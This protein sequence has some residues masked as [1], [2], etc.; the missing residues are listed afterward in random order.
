MK[1]LFLLLFL[2]LAFAGSST[3]LATPCV[4]ELNAATSV[5]LHAPIA[6][7]GQ[8]TETIFRGA[9]P[10][11]EEDYQYLKSIGI[12]TIISLETMSWHI[13]PDRKMAEK[14]G[15]KFVSAPVLGAP[16]QPSE[17]SVNNAL[18]AL[19]SASGE[20]V[21][22]HCFHGRDRTGLLVAMYRMHVQ[23]PRF[24]ADQAWA[25]MATYGYVDR[26]WIH[27]ITEYFWG[28]VSK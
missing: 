26:F 8:V 14:H 25:E 6:R 16:V 19:K 17:A 5:S 22:I 28:H 11:T 21:F 7:F 12:K 2:V 24:T 3:V 13:E 18:E 1:H 27:G 23:Q 4:A 10:E 20:G 9:L 15:I